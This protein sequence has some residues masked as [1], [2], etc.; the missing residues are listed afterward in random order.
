VAA[1]ALAIEGGYYPLPPVVC[2]LDRG[3]GAAIRRARTRLPGGSE[4]PVAIIRVPRERM[5][6]AGI[7]SSLVHEVGHQAAALLNLLPSLRPSLAAL[8]RARGPQALAWRLY[9]RWLSEIMADFWAVARVGVAAPLG[10]M[11]VVSLPRVFVFR[12]GLDDPH[13]FP[14]IRVKIAC[15]FGQALWPHPQ[16]GRLARTWE[17]FYPKDGLDPARARLIELLEAT[18]SAFVTL[19]VQHRPARLRGAS[20]IEALEVRERSPAI[21]R[22]LFRAWR[23]TPQAAAATAPSLAFAVLGQARADGA[24]PPETEGDLTARLLTVWAVRR[25]LG[26]PSRSHSARPARAVAVPAH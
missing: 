10:L 11:G 9:D 16:W 24:L 7:A 8:G 15:A 14:W 26:P 20:L 19:A 6:G 18:L 22:A 12:I 5:V 21:L 1:D 23:S 13:P 2:Y 3:H 4:N 17:S 25:A